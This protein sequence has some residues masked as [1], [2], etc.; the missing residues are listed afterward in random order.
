MTSD[1]RGELGYGWSESGRS[2][3]L[4][5]GGSAAL[6]PHPQSRG[7]QIQLPMDQRSSRDT[8]IRNKHARLAVDS[9]AQFPTIKP[10]HAHRHLPLLGGNRCRPR[11]GR[12]RH[13][14]G[15]WP[16]P[17]AYKHLGS[18]HPGYAGPCAPRIATRAEQPFQVP[19]QLGSQFPQ[20]EQRLKKTG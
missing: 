20:L 17:Q 4:R 3:A 10:R 5:C 6:R 14:T 7:G 13:L 11:S 19:E 8:G 1:Q 12:L 15:P 16:P 2:L 18:P 9:L